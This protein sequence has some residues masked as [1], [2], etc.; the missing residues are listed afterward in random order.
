MSA[1]VSDLVINRNKQPGASILGG[2]DARCVIEILGGTA[3][4]LVS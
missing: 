4:N 1:I 2:N 3:I